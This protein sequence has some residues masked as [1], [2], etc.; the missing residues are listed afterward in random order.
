M[1][2]TFDELMK[3]MDQANAKAA[4]SKDDAFK[5]V[6]NKEALDKAFKDHDEFKKAM[7]RVPKGPI[8]KGR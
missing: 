6:S 8:D 1:T 7:D 5:N 2:E 3:Q 4:K